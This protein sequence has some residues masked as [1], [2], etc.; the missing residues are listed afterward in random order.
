MVLAGEKPD[1]AAN[2]RR[3]YRF[4]HVGILDRNIAHLDVT[5]F[6][7]TDG[8]SQAAVRARAATAAAIGFSANSDAVILDLRDNPGGWGSGANYLPG[9]LLPDGPVHLVS[10]IDRAAAPEQAWTPVVEDHLD[11]PLYVLINDRTASAAECCAYTFAEPAAG[12]HR[13][14][15]Q[16]WCR[17]PR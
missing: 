12:D 7:D 3:N 15:A 13:R 9:H 5:F 17:Q 1:A 11:A 14:D 4:R 2:R 16:R 10:F 8:P 6:C